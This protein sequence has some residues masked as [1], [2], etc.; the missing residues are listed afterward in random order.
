M[1]EKTGGTLLHGLVHKES[2]TEKV[3]IDAASVDM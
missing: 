1:G 2:S 3:G